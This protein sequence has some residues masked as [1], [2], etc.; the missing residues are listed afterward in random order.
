MIV[1][2]LFFQVIQSRFRNDPVYVSEKL[3]TLGEDVDSHDEILSSFF[4]NLRSMLHGEWGG[5]GYCNK[6]LEF[7]D[8][9]ICGDGLQPY[10]IPIY[11]FGIA[12][13]YD[14]EAAAG[15]Y[16]FQVYAFDPTRNYPHDLAKNVNFFNCGL[17]GEV[18]K[19]WSHSSYGDAVGTL[20]SLPQ[21]LKQTNLNQTQKFILKLDCE[22]CE[23]EALSMLK[24]Y[25]KI[26]NKILQ[27][28]IEMHF[29]SSL[30]VDSAEV[31]EHMKETYD[32]LLKYGFIPWFIF[33][34]GGSRA[35]RNHLGK[36]LENGFPG[37]IC[38][39]EIGFLRNPV[40]VI[41]R[42]DIVSPRRKL[43][44]PESLWKWGQVWGK[45]GI[46][47]VSHSELSKGGRGLSVTKN[48]PLRW[49]S[50]ERRENTCFPFQKTG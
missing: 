21:I 47:Y 34:Q 44:R 29:T 27:V 45:A 37:N 20:L 36:V 3:E 39:F 12:D 24:K 42:K 7:G 15:L 23:W 35:D 38:C 26:F 17:R 5:R 1:L 25:P 2:A 6:I 46:E 4:G 16:G 11:S 43:K 50:R 10:G 49:N 41:V 13:D 9:P 14:F 48:I 18:S 28:N 33:P 30:R 31:L 22:G 19:N 40:A 32:L 8:W